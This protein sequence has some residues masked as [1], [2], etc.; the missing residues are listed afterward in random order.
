MH[1]TVVR[2]AAAVALA[3]P[4]PAPLAAQA[5]RDTARASRAGL[6]LQPARSATLT[7]TRGTWMSL[8]VSPDGAT[9]VFDLLGDLY[10]VPVAGGRATRLTGGMAYDAQPRFSP[11]GARIAFTS[12]RSGGDNL[13]ILSTDGR[14]T[15]QVTRGNDHGYISPEWT[16]DGQYLVATRTGGAGS[17]KLWLF[18]TGGGSGVQLIQGPAQLTTVGA[19]FGPDPRYV[20]YATRQGAWTYNA[21]LPEYQLEVYDR[22]TG[23]RTTMTSRY[24]SAFRPTLSPDGRWLVYGSRHDAETGLRIRA[25]ATGEERWLA[26]PVQRDNQEAY[27]DLDVLP[28]YAFT[29]DSRAVVVSYGGRIWRVPVDGS[30]PAPIPFTADVDVP[31]GPELRFDYPVDDGPTLVARQIRDPAPS[32]DGRRLAFTALNHLWVMDLPDGTPRRLTSLD[33]GEFFPAWSPDGRWVA[34]VTWGPSG[35]HV[36]KA[37]ADGR[38]RPE[39]L[40]RAPATYY[41]TAWSPDGGRIV[42]MRADARE[43]QETLQ[44]FGGGSG[45]RFVWVPATGG[46]VT[47]IALAAGRRAPHFTADSGR[48][49]AYG[50]DGLVSFR[51]DGSDERVHV[52]VTGA[53]PP[54]ATGT[55]PSAALV[56]MAPRGDQAVAQVGQHL[57]VLTVPLVGGQVP[58]V[59]TASPE[60]AIVPVRQLTDIGGEFP[61]WSADGRRVHWAIG[62]AFATWDLDRARAVDDSVRAAARAPR[63]AGDTARADTGQRARARYRPEERRIRVTGARDVPQ[64][65]VV[66]RGGRAI[67][68]RGGEIVENA[69]VVVVN[70][71]IAAIGPRGQVA[72]PAG[73]RVIDVAGRTVLPG[74]V[75]T[76]AHFRHSPGVHQ[77]H[78][79]ALLATLAYGVTTTRDPQTG[80][81]D[82]LSYADR[83]EAGDIL[84]P[85]IYSTGPGVFAGERIRDLDHA[86][87]VLR[88][89]SD[90]YDTKTIK[91]YGAGNRQ[92]RQWIAMAARELRLMPTTEGALQHALD[93][94]HMMDG[95]A[96][97]EHNLPIV[98]MYEDVVTLAG[99]A[100]TTLTPT[101]LVSYGGPWAENWWY[102]REDVHGDAKLRR[103]TPGAELDAKTRRR[104]QGAGGS[105]GPGGWFHEDEYAFRR[106]AGFIRDLVEAGGR[107]G[108][109]SHGQLQGL[110]YHWELWTVQS[111]GLAPHDAL[112][113][114]TIMGAEAIGL[115]GQLGS[116]EA[117]KLAD[118]VVLDRDPLADIRNTNS[119]RYVMKNGRL[120]EGDTLDEVWPR[121]RP[122]PPMPWRHAEP[123]PAAGIR[124]GR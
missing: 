106:H 89:Y 6:P 96:G 18:H 17:A 22:V 69:D 79:W 49:F 54:G 76:H 67:T 25:L 121:Q 13:W 7:A 100:Q 61:A 87:N 70:N 38:G 3:A 104:G 35:G 56:L 102:T 83:V 85:R 115:G 45:A 36:W 31:L 86:R 68:M 108:I 91:M 107:A 11:D 8:D 12:D 74:F 58:T 41:Q 55:P 20:W 82:V 33:D 9:I 4:L 124:D 119:V 50:S 92:Q 110:G 51:F 23:A 80:T 77:A 64:G 94:T 120:Y 78:P 28:G 112:R 84:G 24:G 73:A 103:F 43:L 5:A 47:T 26:W 123:A 116:L 27:P 19:A 93:L 52:K 98:P 71:R 113:V 105:P 59:S 90:Y 75:D 81:T 99:T 39:Q 30:A 14:D 2:L 10:T 97:V 48:I 1:A 72:V 44:R 62:N 63:P 117:G 29:P 114:A 111:G 37:P 118:L 95:Y 66:L 57:F 21:I 46:E 16:P 42:A 32:P 34:F 101:L 15:V 40:T 65:A 122:A 53:S 109:G 88:R 60:S